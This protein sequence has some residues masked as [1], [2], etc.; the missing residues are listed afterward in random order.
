MYNLKDLSL[1]SGMTD[2]TLRTYLKL[3]MLS[4]EKTDGVWHFTEE[5]IQ[6]FLENEYVR[7][8]I[9]AKRNALIFDYLRADASKENTACIVLHLR[10][11]DSKAVAKFFC[12]AVNKRRCLS[13]TFDENK[14]E[15]KVILVGS[16]ETVY[17]VLNEY[18][19]SKA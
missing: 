12:E 5:Q 7:P 2:R 17:D 4:G 16:E 9:K 18:H 1:I 10:G 19:S 3:G 15:N 14:G 11:D 13:M 8:A 6:E